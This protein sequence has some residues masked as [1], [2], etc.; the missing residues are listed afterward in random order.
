MCLD[1]GRARRLTVR[2][3]SDKQAPQLR[4]FQSALHKCSYLPNNWARTVVPDPDATLSPGIYSVLADLGFR[5][6]GAMIYRPMCPDCSACVPVRMD[7]ALFKARRSQR[8][9]WRKNQDLTIT[10][11]S[12]EFVPEHFA[13]YRR[14][15]KHRHG[16]GEMANHNEDDYRDFLFSSWCKTELVEM[17]ED[18]RLVAVSVLDV[19]R[20]GLSA[21]YTFFEPMDSGR[22]PGVQAILW[23]LEL[24]RKRD[25]A[26]LYLGY[27][28]EACDKMSYKSDYLPQQRLI[29][30]QWL[31]VQE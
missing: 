6:S 31:E 24:T 21:V 8:R 2:P 17:R 18:G 23:A 13:L 4:F 30:G 27:W 14:Y 28:I 11:R 26:W 29:D 20:D 16:D 3:M 15:Q 5:R 25:L 12:A 9:V 19:L 7:P 10:T 1:L 22:S